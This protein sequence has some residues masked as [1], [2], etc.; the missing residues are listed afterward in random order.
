MHRVEKNKIMNLL[1][2]SFDERLSPGDQRLL[3]E[4]LEKDP[5][6]KAEKESLKRLRSRMAASAATAFPPLFADRILQRLGEEPEESFM[7]DLL[8]S[9]RKV[10]WIGA[11]SIILLLVNNYLNSGDLSVNSLLAMPQLSIEEAFSV[12]QWL[13]GR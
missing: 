3:D 9:F 1:Y 4:A 13:G 11:A 6:L 2:R 8:W 7:E 10:I 5:Q 12:D